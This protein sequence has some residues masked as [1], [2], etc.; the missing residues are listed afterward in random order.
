VL[1]D[2]DP[3]AYIL[4]ANVARR[5]LTKGQRAIMDIVHDEPV[6]IGVDDQDVQVHEVRPAD[7]ERLREWHDYGNR[8]PEPTAGDTE[9]RRAQVRLASLARAEDL[10]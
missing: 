5:C 7:F 3:D 9:L 2:E 10:A 6:R 1:N 4:S 8:H